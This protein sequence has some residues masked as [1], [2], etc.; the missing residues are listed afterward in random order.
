MIRQVIL[1]K[2]NILL[3]GTNFCKKYYR[4]CI[5]VLKIQAYESTSIKVWMIRIKQ[6]SEIKV[7]KGSGHVANFSFPVIE[8]TLKKKNEFGAAGI[9]H[10]VKG[11]G[12][13]FQIQLVC[14][15]IWFWM[16]QVI[17]IN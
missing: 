8:C 4:Y 3:K 16:Q 1:R 5:Q 6:A 9:V 10:R 17:L 11:D 7:L 14:P 12:A 15:L 2:I 13:A